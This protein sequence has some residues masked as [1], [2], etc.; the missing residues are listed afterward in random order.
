MREET[1]HKPLRCRLGLH[2]WSRDGAMF[3][4]ADICVYCTRPANA[5]DAARLALERELWVESAK[6][7]GHDSEAQSHYVGAHLTGI[8]LQYVPPRPN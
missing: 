7:V 5:D 2:R 6:V 1:T 3:S 8:G 4:S